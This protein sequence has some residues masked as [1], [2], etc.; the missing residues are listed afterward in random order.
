M[1]LTVTN[2]W[3]VLGTPCFM[4]PIKEGI[5]LNLEN[6]EMRPHLITIAEFSTNSPINGLSNTSSKSWETIFSG[7]GITWPLKPNIGGPPFTGCLQ[8]FSRSASYEIQPSV[9]KPNQPH[10]ATSNGRWDLCSLSPHSMDHLRASSY[11]FQSPVAPP[12]LR[13][14]STSSLWE[15]GNMGLSAIGRANNSAD[16]G[17]NDNPGSGY[18]TDSSDENNSMHMTLEMMKEIGIGLCI[19]AQQSKVF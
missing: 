10:V 12:N 17:E 15:I 2:T 7:N 18:E 8:S 3:S 16:V 5:T 6:P 13:Q 1:G 9:G 11:E 14:R 4:L 19:K